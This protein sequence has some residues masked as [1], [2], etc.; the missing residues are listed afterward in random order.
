MI[1]LGVVSLVGNGYILW[2]YIEYTSYRER[3]ERELDELSTQYKENVKERDA[4]AVE[5]VSFGKKK[6]QLLS[7]EKRSPE[8]QATLDGKRQ[9][10]SRLK[11][12]IEQK[13]KELQEKQETLASLNERHSSLKANTEALDNKNAQ[14]QESFDKLN[15]VNSVLSEDYQKKGEEL[16]LLKTELGETEKQ[17]QTLQAQVN[18][19]QQSLSEMQGNMAA[20]RREEQQLAEST[21]NL[22]TERDEV[23]KQLAET[24][25]KMDELS[26]SRANAQCMET[27]RKLTS[28]EEMI[29]AAETELYQKSATAKTASEECAEQ[30]RKRDVAKVECEKLETLKEEK[31]ARFNDLRQE[32]E[33]L[34]QKKRDLDAQ[35]TEKNEALKAMEKDIAEF[36]QKRASLQSECEK[37]ET[38]LTQKQEGH[39][40]L[41]EMGQ[42][43]K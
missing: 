25:R 12:S 4:L 24:Q 19:L 5:L 9:E 43:K 31:Q 16:R 36:G 27:E 23:Q 22:R 11:G 15:A 2:D 30:I 3:L 39:R 8:L 29:R 18:K 26:G 20:F 14:A 42:D 13:N 41:R 6:N 37:T 17:K 35:T 1:P 40:E 38:T 7:I 28:L 21:K 10:E 34:E 33:S 32:Y